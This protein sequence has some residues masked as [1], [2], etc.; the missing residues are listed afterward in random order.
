MATTAAQK[1]TGP[2]TEGLPPFFH[3]FMQWAG[4]FAMPAHHEQSGYTLSFLQN[5]VLGKP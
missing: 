5:E 2:S 3:P 4:C 1:L